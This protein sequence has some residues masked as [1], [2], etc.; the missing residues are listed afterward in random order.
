MTRRRV[1][2]AK[3]AGELG[4]SQDAVRM[5]V[6]RGTLDATKEG[7]QLFVLLDSAGSGDQS[8][9]DSA[10]LISELRAHNETLREQLVSERQ[11]HAEAR[12][13]IAGLVER[14]PP[15]LE[16]RESPVSP[17][18][19]SE[20]TESPRTPTERLRRPQRGRRSAPGGV[21]SS[22]RE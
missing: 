18:E 21:R 10:A 1:T 20:G 3:A 19:A 16:A 17:A 15:A 8:Q 2:V 12:R 6:K 13:I 9:H 7:R 5:R 4:I 22:G 14:L 11:A